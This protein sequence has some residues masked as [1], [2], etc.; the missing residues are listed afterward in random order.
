M[1]EENEDVMLFKIVICENFKLS[2]S[3]SIDVI[4]LD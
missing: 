1:F 4:V 2:G 3:K